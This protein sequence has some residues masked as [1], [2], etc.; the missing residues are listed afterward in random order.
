M[1]SALEPHPCPGP[2]PPLRPVRSPSLQGSRGLHSLHPLG[3]IWRSW[4]HRER[5]L[6]EKTGQG[7]GTKVGSPGG[8]GTLTPHCHPH[9]VPRQQVHNGE[10]SRL[11]S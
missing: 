1:V 4:R 6:L 3:P 9:F 5:L 11:Q 7:R 8:K 2:N 10:V